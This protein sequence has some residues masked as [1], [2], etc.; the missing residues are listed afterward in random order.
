[1]MERSLDQICKAWRQA[2]EQ[3]PSSRQAL[4]Q[5]CQTA[6]AAAAKAMAQFGCHW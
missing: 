1:M 2:A 6:A 4:A 3:S 5:A